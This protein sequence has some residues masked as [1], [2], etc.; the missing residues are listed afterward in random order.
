MAAGDF[1]HCAGK[2][3]GVPVGHREQA[4]RLEDAGEFRGDDGGTR[5]KHG[6]K[7][8]DDGVEGAAG[9]RKIFG[10]AFVEGNGELLGGCSFASLNQ[11]VGRDV[12]AGDD[13]STQGGRDRS[14]AG[15]AGDV[16]HAHPGLEAE[17]VDEGVRTSSN[18][19][20]HDAEVAGHPAR[21]HGGFNFFDGQ[22]G[23]A[24]CSLRWSQGQESGADKSA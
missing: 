1:E 11:K 23:G 15:A 20:S 13:G 14:V 17:A 3:A 6:P 19:F 24:H 10:V 2:A 12:D 8:G 7:H 9:V 5:R 21:A 4:A 16:E 18:G 22:F